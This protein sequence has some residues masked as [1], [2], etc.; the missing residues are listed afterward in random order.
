MSSNGVHLSNQTWKLRLFINMTYNNPNNI[1]CFCHK[2][3]FAALRTSYPYRVLKYKAGTNMHFAKQNSRKFFTW[4][5]DDV[6][7]G[8]PSPF[9][10]YPFLSVFFIQCC[11]HTY[12][13]GFL[14][15]RF[16]ICVAS[17]SNNCV[18]RLSSLW[19][20]LYL[21]NEFPCDSRRL[22]VNFVSVPSI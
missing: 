15:F 22:P 1:D 8:M 5:K 14:L 2:G 9:G 4:N 11:L 6:W 18:H 21:P 7:F 16:C 12:S 13:W 17:C 3:F 10:L 19:G 20:T